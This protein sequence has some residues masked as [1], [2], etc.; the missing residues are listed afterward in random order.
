MMSNKNTSEARLKLSH[1]NIVFENVDFVTIKTS[2]IEQL[3]IDNI[4]ESK[5]LYNQHVIT[6]LKCEQLHLVLKNQCKNQKT[7]FQENYED[8]SSTLFSRMLK[9][10]DIVTIELHYKNKTQEIIY[11][12][13]DGNEENKNQKTYIDKQDN[14]VVEIMKESN[15]G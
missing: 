12:P 15:C 10:N 13:Y 4:S 5:H 14:L 11:V 2:N 8:D 6:S 1:I 9:Y 3:L 7:H